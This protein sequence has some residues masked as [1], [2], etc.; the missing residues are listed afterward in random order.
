MAPKKT[1]RQSQK[2]SDRKLK[3]LFGVIKLFLKKFN[4]V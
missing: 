1:I 3:L 2:A 4:Q